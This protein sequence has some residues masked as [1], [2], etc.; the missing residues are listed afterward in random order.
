M[1][2]EKSQAPLKEKQVPL[3]TISNHIYSGLIPQGMVAE[4]AIGAARE[5]NGKL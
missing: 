3:E 2:L 5:K 4:G 1:S